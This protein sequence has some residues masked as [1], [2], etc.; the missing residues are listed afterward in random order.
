[1]YAV[2]HPAVTLHGRFFAAVLACGAGSAVSHRSA[3]ELL[4]LLR[5][6]PGP[7]H[8]TRTGAHRDGPDGVVLHRT[9]KLPLATCHGI[10]VTTAARALVDL[11]AT[12]T[13]HDLG[14][15]L[16]QARIRRLVTESGLLDAVGHQRPGTTR[17]KEL[18]AQDPTFTRS[19]AERALRRLVV[20]AQL[21]HPATN[22]YVGPY[23]VDALWAPQRL[24]VEFDSWEFHGHREAFERDR[25]RDADLQADGY[26]VI[27]VTWR[28][29]TKQPEALTARL[30]VAIAR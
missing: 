20:K 13:T 25:V 9:T 1:V 6:V 19:K 7:I 29:L 21:P 3:T 12:A 5:P 26:R 15:A 18:L 17:L 8:V 27:R 14:R 2:G 11:A 10:P 28:Q 4:E 30:A 22:V 24:V 23:E 16:E